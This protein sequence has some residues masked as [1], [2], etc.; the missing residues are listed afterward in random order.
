MEYD[1]YIFWLDAN[2]LKI[3]LILVSL[4]KSEFKRLEI[5]M[6]D[7]HIIFS[8]STDSLFFWQPNAT[9]LQWCKYCG[10]NF[11]IV[12]ECL[13]STK[14]SLKFKTVECLCMSLCRLVLNNSILTRARRTPAWMATGVSSGRPSATSPI[15]NM[16]GTFV[17]SAALVNIFPFLNINK[18]IK[19]K[20]NSHSC[21]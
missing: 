21:I 19:E 12:H 10:W 13:W 7:F 2:K 17:C 4:R 14:Q 11:V 18:H 15:A 6:I 8:V 16:V 1:N 20:Y 5:C 9:I 3:T